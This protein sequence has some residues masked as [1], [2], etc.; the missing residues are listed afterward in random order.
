FAAA[1]NLISRLKL[2]AARLARVDGGDTYVVS[3][4]TDAIA[5]ATGEDFDVEAFIAAEDAKAEGR[6]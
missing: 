2:A 6:S 3:E 4:I 1:P 5:E